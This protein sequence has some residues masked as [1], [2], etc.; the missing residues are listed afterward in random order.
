MVS[1]PSKPR[2]PDC[3]TTVP[4]VT[5]AKARTEAASHGEQGFTARFPLCGILLTFILLSS[6]ARQAARPNPSPTPP[7]KLASQSQSPAPLTESRHDFWPL[8]KVLVVGIFDLDS[9]GIF[10]PHECARE[11][12]DPRERH[13]NEHVLD[14]PRESSSISRYFL[15]LIPI[16]QAPS[17][18]MG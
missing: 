1:Y 13:Q 16:A 17:H 12:D 8:D 11:G 10:A 14:A 6:K 15:P 4:T 9:S 18:L 5:A 2:L 3:R 7:A